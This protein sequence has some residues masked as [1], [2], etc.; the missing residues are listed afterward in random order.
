MAYTPPDKGI[1]GG[2]ERWKNWMSELSVTTCADCIAL[3]GK[4]YPME[5][6]VKVPGHINGKCAVV[7]M[8]TIAAGTVSEMGEDGVDVYLI[9]YGRLPDYYV[10]K[11]EALKA[12]WKNNGNTLYDVLPDKMIGGDV[13]TTMKE[14][15][16]QLREEYGEKLILIILWEQEIH[17]EFCIRTMD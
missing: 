11:K 8:R 10:S 9:K 1:G 16:R 3:H 7:P 5:Q 13:I 6:L 4:I 17:S 15:C 2:S 12:G 14:S